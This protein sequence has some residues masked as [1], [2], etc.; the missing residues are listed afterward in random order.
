MVVNILSGF[1][2]EMLEDYVVEK[3]QENG[4][5]FIPA[6]ELDRDGYNEPLLERNLTSY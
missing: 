2:E 6:K 1:D 4:W 5:K 3:F